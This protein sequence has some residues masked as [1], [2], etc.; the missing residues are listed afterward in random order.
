MRLA[1]PD[2]WL[3]LPGAG[4]V[5]PGWDEKATVKSGAPGRIRSF[6]NLL[7]DWLSPPRV[8][9]HYT[10]I[11]CDRMIFKIVRHKCRV[12]KDLFQQFTHINIW[13]S[14]QR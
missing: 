9:G 5:T 2:T 6:G 3:T 8:N 4:L 14:Q 10:S 13:M 11:C 1:P 12:R 7:G